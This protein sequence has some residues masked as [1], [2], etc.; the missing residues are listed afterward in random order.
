MRLRSFFLGG[1][2]LG[3]A[4]DYGHRVAALCLNTF[5]IFSGSV[6]IEEYLGGSAT[7]VS[8]LLAFDHYYVRAALVLDYE[9]ARVL[10][11]R[12]NCVSSRREFCASRI[13]V[14]R[15]CEGYVQTPTLR[16]RRQT[17]GQHYYA[18]CERSHT[19]FL[20]RS[21]SWAFNLLIEPSGD[22]T[23]RLFLR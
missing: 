21:F 16:H 10:R 5:E 13:E 20:H 17:T 11:L 1:D 6:A 9:D 12:A 14:E 8:R 18:C 7:I 19:Y 23:R 22:L 4:G 15:R 2:L 3:N